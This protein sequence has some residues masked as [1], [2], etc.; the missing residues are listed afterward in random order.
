MVRESAIRM[1]IHKSMRLLEKI[2]HE[3]LYSWL[4]RPK[5]RRYLIEKLMKTRKPITGRLPIISSTDRNFK[6]TVNVTEHLQ[7]KPNW[8]EK[9]DETAD[10]KTPIHVRKMDTRWEPKAVLQIAM[11]GWVRWQVQCI[12]FVSDDHMLSLDMI[13]LGT[14]ESALTPTGIWLDHGNGS[15]IHELRNRTSKEYPDIPYFI[16]GHSMGSLPL[17]SVLAKRIMMMYFSEGLAGAIVMGTWP[18]ALVFVQEVHWHP[19]FKRASYEVTH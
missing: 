16:L 11:D 7:A 19:L 8:W 18:Y 17:A 15:D 14:G 9:I 3:G 2:L 4:Q 10:A 12:C 6:V 13:C 1:R 5:W